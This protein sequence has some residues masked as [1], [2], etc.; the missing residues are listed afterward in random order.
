MQWNDGNVFLIISRRGSGVKLSEGETFPLSTVAAPRG[1]PPSHP[2]GLRLHEW[3]IPLSHRLP[4]PPCTRRVLM[5]GLTHSVD[6]LILSFT[7]KSP[8]LPKCQTHGLGKD[9]CSLSGDVICSH[10]FPPP[11]L[12][13][14]LAKILSVAHDFTRFCW[15]CLLIGL[16]LE[17]VFSVYHYSIKNT[18]VTVVLGQ[19]PQCGSG[20]FSHRTCYLSGGC[21][22]PG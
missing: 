5:F 16:W 17:A 10:D 18:P 1:F 19:W 15:I 6:L 14:S 9:Q 12:P 7:F 20:P 13:S 4:R 3:I 21:Q 22:R 2:Q 8:F 11:P